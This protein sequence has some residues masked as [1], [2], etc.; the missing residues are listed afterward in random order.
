MGLGA[1]EY[2]LQQQMLQQIQPKMKT[3]KVRLYVINERN[4]GIM[5]TYVL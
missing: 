3:D 2:H 5:Q 4:V 1:M